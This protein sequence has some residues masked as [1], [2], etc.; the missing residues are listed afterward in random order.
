MNILK[1]KKNKPALCGLFMAVLATQSATATQQAVAEQ[2]ALT[3][4]QALQYT[5]ENNPELKLYPLYLR[6]ADAQQLQAEVRPALQAGLA[7]DNAFGTGNKSSLDEAEISLTLSQSIE[8]GGKRDQRLSFSSA[9]RQRLQAEYALTRLDTL[10]ETSR[11]YYRLLSQ[12]AKIELQQQRIETEKKALQVIQKRAS[13]GAV[14]QADVSNMALRLASSKIEEKSLQSQVLA[15]KQNLAAMWLGKTEFNLVLGDL[16]QLPELPNNLHLQSLVKDS[17]SELPDYRYQVALQRLADSQLALAQANGRAD[18]DVGIGLRQFEISGDQALML[19]LS[20]PLNFS[21]P[22]R[23]RIAAAQAQKQL[24][25]EQADMKHQQLLLN[26]TRLQQTLFSDVQNAKSIE[27]E[28]LPLASELL[29]NTQKAYKQGRY[30]VLQWIDAQNQAFELEQ[31]LI[32]IRIRI[33]N[34]ILELERITGQPIVTE[35]I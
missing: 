29:S 10:A 15:A 34:Q 30:S 16:S 12:Q 26:L 27:E 21:N 1:M 24:S 11:R 9:E 17:I 4:N 32:D 8:L 23:G 6:Q 33:F 3:L 5:Q 25:F 22:N 13:A 20:M 14:S 19:N 31:R 18:L 28:L 7:L 35:N 2:K